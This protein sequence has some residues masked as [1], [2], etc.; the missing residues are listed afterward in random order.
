MRPPSG[1]KAT[2][3]RKPV[4]AG[5]SAWVRASESGILGVMVALGSRVKKGTLRGVVADPFGE[6]ETQITASFNGI[7][8]GRTNLPLVNEG[9][10]LYHIARFEDIHEIEAKVDE[11][12]EEH[13]PEPISS[14]NP[15]S[16]II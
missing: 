15:E 12:Q 5:S 16:P 3:K 6:A 2:K 4:V 14:P 7:V 11:F 9:D 10:A 13:S 1:R 8:I